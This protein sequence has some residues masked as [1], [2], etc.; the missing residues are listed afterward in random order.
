MLGA[1]RREVIVSFTPPTPE[2]PRQLIVVVDGG[3]PSVFDAVEPVSPSPADLEDYLGTYFSEELN[4]EWVLRIT[5]DS[6]S[7]WDPRIRSERALL[8][9]F[10]R[11][12]FSAFGWR[13][14]YMFSRDGQGR[15][16][17]FANNSLRLR[18]LRFVKR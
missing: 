7:I 15:V 1:E 14:F 2:Q 5:N 17:G 6:L 13:V 10:G 8:A 16:V 4:Y 9:P 18:N 11:D 12:V 3:K